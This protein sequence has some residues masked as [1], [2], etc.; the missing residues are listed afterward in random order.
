MRSLRNFS[1]REWL[2]LLPL[3][4][5][6]KQIR[7]DAWLAAYQRRKPRELRSFLAQTR[8]LA[9][10]DV[11]L[12]IAFEQPWA[13][14]WLLKMARRHLAGTT[15]LVFDNSRRA[16]ARASIEQV[17]REHG[18]PYLPLPLNRT[19]HVNRSHG[20]AMSWVYRNVVR[21][22]RPRLFGYI[23][24]DLIPVAPLRVSDRTG[25]QP[26]YGLP[27]NSP[28]AWQLWAGYCLFRYADV[29]GKRLNFLY[30]FSQGLDTGG[31]NWHSLYRMQERGRLRFAPSQ[32]VE[33]RDPVTGNAAQ[34]Q[35]IDDAW[36]HIGG[37]SYNE[38]F[39]SKSELCEHLAE[40]FD[41]GRSWDQ[42]RESRP[43]A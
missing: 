27:V 41:Q 39:K 42:I 23:D 36:L 37:I 7:N 9:G 8:K 29:A 15:V 6:L 34:V 32:L 14:G 13:L 17:C 43:A 33:V 12:V 35:I 20:M 28:W 25:S 16:D 19:R 5:A 30:D 1:A 40:A 2:Q 22:I 26:L 24:H 4:H 21:E 38:N 10:Q 11:L 31:R 18:A 3:Q